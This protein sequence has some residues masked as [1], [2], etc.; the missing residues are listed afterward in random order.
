MFACIL[1]KFLRAGTGAKV[2]MGQGLIL[3]QFVNKK[4]GYVLREIRKIQNVK[5]EEGVSNFTR[6]CNLCSF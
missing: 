3:R 1:Q 5:E 6:E 2:S 4:T